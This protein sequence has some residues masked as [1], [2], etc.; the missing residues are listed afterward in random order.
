[1]HVT[2]QTTVAAPI[3]TVWDKLCNHAE[4]SGWA[5]GIT[6]TL[7]EPGTTDPN[8]V[9]AIRRIASPGPGQDVSRKS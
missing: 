3:E 2:S 7:D 8:G 5:P 1:M 4:M 9:G 6:V